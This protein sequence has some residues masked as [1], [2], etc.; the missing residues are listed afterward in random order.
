[1]RVNLGGNFGVGSGTA[2]QYLIVPCCQAA[3]MVRV[4]PREAAEI[5]DAKSDM[6]LNSEEGAKPL[7]QQLFDLKWE[8]PCII[9][10]FL[11]IAFERCLLSIIAGESD[12]AKLR[13]L[14]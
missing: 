3:T 1:M 13:R 5:F 6:K 4:L 10:V 11:T 9:T 12:V 7:P 14:A 2:S 8:Y